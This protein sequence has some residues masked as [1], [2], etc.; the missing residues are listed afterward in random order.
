MEP[1]NDPVSVTT[2]ARLQ[3]STLCQTDAKKGPGPGERNVGNPLWVAQNGIA[4][5][6]KLIAPRKERKDTN[7]VITPTCRN[8]PT[9]FTRRLQCQG[10]FV[11]GR[12]ASGSCADEVTQFDGFLLNLED[13]GHREDWVSPGLGYAEN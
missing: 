11:S 3:S 7:A 12:P 13:F 2:K 6:L 8:W 1:P 10:V 9:A 5:H 4:A